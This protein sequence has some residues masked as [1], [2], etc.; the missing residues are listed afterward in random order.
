[1]NGSLR[2]SMAWL[3][4]WT[5]LLSGWLLLVVCITGTAAYYRDEISLWMQPERHGGIPAAATPAAQQQAARMAVARLQQIAPHADS[6][7]IDLPQPRKPYTGISWSSQRGERPAPGAG[8][9]AGNFASATLD[10]H[11]H[12]LPDAR[13]T[14]GGGFFAVFH[15]TLHYLPVLWGR[16]I[17]SIATMVMFVALI[18][19][20]ITHRR[21][22]ADFFTFRPGKGQRSWLDAHNALGV[23]ALPFHTMICYS[24]LVTLMLLTMPWA[25]KHLYP[26][27]RNDFV[28]AVFPQAPRLQAAAGVP[29]PLA[30]IAPVLAQSAQHW[31]GALAAR[32][33]VQRPNDAAARYIVQRDEAGRLSNQRQSLFF[34]GVDGRLTDRA[35]D[36]PSAVAETRN[37]L[38]GLHI[39]RFAEPWLRG[40]LFFSG[41]ACCA[42]MATGMLL[43][44]V[45]ASLRKQPPRG[46][47]LA[48]SLNI[49]TVA[50][51]PAAMAAYFWLNRL[52]P[53]DLVQRAAAEI[54][55]FFICWGVLSIAALFWPARAMWMAQLILGAVLFA[56]LPLL[57]AASAP[58]KAYAA[59]L[60][61]GNG[62]VAATDAGLLLCGALLGWAGW[63]LRPT[64]LAG[65]AEVTP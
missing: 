8:R 55:G 39:G 29:A 65:T 7:I 24:G 16:W 15:F 5:A 13:N 63:R 50:A 36:M 11:G 48:E 51:L 47:R 54:N 37:S 27:Q 1:M 23:L 58:A 21:F 40:L 12:L 6:W 28:G 41:L 2:Q 56:G 44:T 26:E 4:T 22:F 17:V 10:G 38:I 25:V 46:L 32:V 3:H 34:S 31:Q 62:L 20:V 61:G 19:G 14:R 53:P 35:G 45:K 42:M 33:T 57:N 43:W 60:S 59:L 64:P 18:S 49:I 52:L 9:P 30:D